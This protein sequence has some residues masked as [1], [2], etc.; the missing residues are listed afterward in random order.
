MQV[1][2]GSYKTGIQKVDFPLN[3]QLSHIWAKGWSKTV[4]LTHCA[5]GTPYG[6]IGL[7]QH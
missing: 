1:S 4:M 7:G 3:K 5:L 2:E 6:N